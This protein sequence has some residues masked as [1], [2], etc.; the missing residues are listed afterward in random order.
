MSAA[1]ESRG[2][3]QFVPSAALHNVAR[4]EHDGPLGTQPLEHL[5]LMVEQ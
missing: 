4:F 3:A 1:G 2:A 5:R